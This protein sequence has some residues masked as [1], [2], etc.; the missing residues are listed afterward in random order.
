VFSPLWVMLGL[1]IAAALGLAGGAQAA[2]Y[3]LEPDAVWTAGDAQPHPGWVVLVQDQR[4][5]AVGPK[6][7]VAAP[8]GAETIALPGE[9]LIPGL[10][11]LH[12]H[13]FSTP[14]TRRCGTIRC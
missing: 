5:A 10:I 6:G 9:T 1:T 8:A 11:E 7:Q 12:S 2:T 14:T 4:T 13:L 3:V